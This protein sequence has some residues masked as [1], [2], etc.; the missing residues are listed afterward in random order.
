MLQ[1]VLDWQRAGNVLYPTQKRV[2][3]SAHTQRAYR[4]DVMAFVKFMGLTWPNE[5]TELLRVSIKYV[6]AFRATC[7]PEAPHRRPSADASAP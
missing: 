1:N 2:G 4:E 7:W 6:Q 3:S 5:A